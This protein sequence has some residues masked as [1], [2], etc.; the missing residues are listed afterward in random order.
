MIVLHVGASARG[1]SPNPCLPQALTALPAAGSV[2]GE[3]DAVSA[4]EW[5]LRTAS[6][7]FADMPAGLVVSSTDSL[8][9]SRCSEDGA[10]KAGVQCNLG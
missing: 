7:L 3:T 9:L 5:A 10:L 8:L 6:R 1:G 4:A 2:P